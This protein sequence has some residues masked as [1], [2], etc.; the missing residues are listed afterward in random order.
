MLKLCLGYLKSTQLLNTYAN[1]IQNLF[2]LDIA[3]YLLCNRKFCF[4]FRLASYVFTM[5]QSK[6]AFTYHLDLHFYFQQVSQL[7]HSAMYI[8]CYVM[9]H[10]CSLCFHCDML[11]QLYH[12][13]KVTQL[14]HKRLFSCVTHM[15]NNVVYAFP[16]GMLMVQVK[17]RSQK[18]YFQSIKQ[19]FKLKNL[20]IICQH[21]FCA[22]RQSL[23]EK[24]YVLKALNRYI[25]HSC[26]NFPFQ[27]FPRVSS[28]EMIPP[29]IIFFFYVSFGPSS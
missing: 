29:S 15:R 6:I 25:H 8:L 18:A 20:K 7:L 16:L 24:I 2:S 9:K 1:T 21:F 14:L 22:C 28:L 10:I 23:D 3:M 13:I 19:C 5:H 11:I 27:L 17:Q 4:S 26:L 12:E